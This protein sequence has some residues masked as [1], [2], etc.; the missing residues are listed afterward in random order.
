MDLAIEEMFKKDKQKNK[1]KGLD[2]NSVQAGAPEESDMTLNN[3]GKAN[4]R[5]S[6]ENPLQ[7]LSKNEA[8]LVPEF[9]DTAQSKEKA[10][11]SKVSNTLHMSTEESEFPQQVSSTPMFSENTVHPRHEVSPK[12]SSKN[13]QL[14]QENISKSSGYSKQTNYS[15]TPKSLAKTTHP[16]QGSTL[17]PATNSTHYREDDIPKSSEDIIQ[18]KK[19]DRP[20]SSEDSVQSKEGEVHKPLKDSIQSKETKVP[21]S[22][23][24]SIQSK[25]DKTD[26]K[27]VV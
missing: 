20:K 13:T 16:K 24:D 5:G 11:A 14:K 1:D 27:S 19:E 18:P 17:K 3:G 15:N 2:M 25:E 23:Q 21:K 8:F 4:E 10:I 26:R 9:L 6:N 12:P 22:P 7:A